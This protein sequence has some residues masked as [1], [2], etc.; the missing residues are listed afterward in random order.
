MAPDGYCESEVDTDV[1][2]DVLGLDVPCVK[3]WNSIAATNAMNVKNR[4][5]RMGSFYFLRTFLSCRELSSI[6]AR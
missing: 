5:S 6:I 1:L 3:T 4:S 2:V